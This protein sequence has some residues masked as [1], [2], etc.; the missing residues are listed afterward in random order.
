MKGLFLRSAGLKNRLTSRRE[1]ERS[2]TVFNIL[3]FDLV[4]VTW[5]RRDYGTGLVQADEALRLCNDD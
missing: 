2:A 1:R 4:E 5:F 3:E